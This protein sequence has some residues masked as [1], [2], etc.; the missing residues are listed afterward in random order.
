MRIEYLADHQELVPELARLHFS[1]WGHMHP[2]ETL[3]GRTRRLREACGREA[4]PVVLVALEGVA[5]C[6]SA[7]LVE[8]DMDTRADLE[9]WLAGVYVVPEYRHRG[10]GSALVRR[11]VSDAADLGVPELY[12]YTPDAAEFYSRL[13]WT[14]LDRCGYLGEQVVV[15]SMRPQ[16]QCIDTP[17]EIHSANHV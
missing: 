2:G 9:P 15:M 1:Q 10:V 14:V 3:E 11:V 12:L 7:M 8:H 4:I 6:G 5:L 16:G 13:G 17:G